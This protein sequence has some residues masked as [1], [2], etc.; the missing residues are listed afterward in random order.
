MIPRERL[1]NT[2]I[3]YFGDAF[4]QKYK[5]RIHV[6]EGDISKPNIGLSD[7]SMEIIKNNVTTVINSGAIVKHFGQRDLFEKINVAGTYNVVQICKSFQKRLIH[8]STIS[9]SGNGEREETV[10]E[11]PENINDKVV[12]SERDLYVKQKLNNSI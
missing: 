6:L 5:Q 10:I 1:R 11:T 12:F 2:L 8:V 9:I 3:Y 7:E 4:Y